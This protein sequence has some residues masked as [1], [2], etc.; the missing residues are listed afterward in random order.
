MESGNQTFVLT[1]DTKGIWRKLSPDIPMDETGINRYF[2]DVSTMLTS[3]LLENCI[4]LASFR[5]EIIDD[6]LS[7]KVKEFLDTDKTFCL[8]LDRFLLSAIEGDEAYQDKFARFSIC[9]TSDG[10]RI[11]RITDSNFSD[12]LA[13]LNKRVPDIA[14]RQIMIVDDGVFT[15]GTVQE[16]VQKYLSTIGIKNEQCTVLGFIGNGGQEQ[17]SDQNIST[18][19][20]NPIRNLYDWVDLR[21]FGIFG[22]KLINQE[23]KNGLWYATPYVYPWSDGKGASFDMFDNFFDISSA[24]IDAQTSLFL[25]WESALGKEIT[26]SDIQKAGFTLPTDERKTLPAI[27]TMRVVD[28]LLSCDAY[29]EKEQ[30]REVV[31]FDMDGT[32][33]QLDGENN[34]YGGS[35]LERKVLQNAQAYIEMLA[36]CSSSEAQEAVKEGLE[37]PIGLSAYVR[38]KFGVSRKEYFDAVWNINPE[39]ILQNYTIP[40]NKIRELEKTNKKLVLVTSAPNIWQTKV[41]EYLGI[42]DAFESIYTGEDFELKQEIFSMLS[43]R[44]KPQNI[45]S[46]GDQEETDVAPAKALG[47]N[48]ILISSPDQ[49]E[50]I[51]I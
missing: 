24:I 35:Q 8:C 21:D 6:A 14:D 1:E 37:D 23:D 16:T 26:F 10:K 30:N 11:P 12:Q 44:Y 39:G 43:K 7:K 25:S 40:V 33:Y 48:A 42:T 31:L 41:T 36:E 47:W 13:A 49:L 19:I 34:G 32:L 38:Q 46:I 4:D 17:L 50:R 3:S 51:A 2:S 20:I 22:G 29:I 15:G 5:E 9:R 45:I 28:Y 27:P 18:D